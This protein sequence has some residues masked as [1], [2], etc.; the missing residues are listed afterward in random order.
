MEYINNELCLG[1]LKKPLLPLCANYMR[2]IYVYDLDFLSA[3]FKTMSQHLKGVRL[4]YA[5][6]ANSNPEI[7]Q[8]LKKL[9]AGADVVSLGEIK[10]ALE[11]GFSVQ[12]IVYS[13][14][15]KTRH[16]ITEALKLGIYQIN[17]ESLPELERI[18]AL[19]RS[20]NK[21]T[22]IALRLNPDIDIKTHPYIATGLKDN[23]FGMELGLIPELIK[24]LK[25]YAD[26]IEL[27][28]VSLHLG[29]MMMEFSGYQEALLKLKSVFVELQKEFSTLKRFD[30]GGGL[31]IFYDR[32]DLELEESL[33]K[34]YAKITLE[35]LG[36]LNCELQSEPGRWLVGHC[37]ALITQVQYI[38][39]TKDKT[40]VIVDAGMN[41]LIRPSLYEADH[42]ILP[43]KKASAEMKADIVGP[44]C[45]S[46]DFFAK[47]RTLG[48]VS[49]GDF[50]AVLDSGAYGY[51]MASIY[52]LQELP[53][54]ICI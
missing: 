24:T 16:E 3:R 52:N 27:V 31:G 20:L 50:V 49:E 41:H 15:G 2:P 28:G 48:S 54:E 34:D 12:D 5:M 22:S 17:V 19:A 26:C 30:F 11:S 25:S 4:F 10:R 45:E 1:P 18:G 38:K 23:K 37:G 46:S 21:K 6:K 44:I 9:G 35:T 43:L 7:L 40:F 8:Q 39:K 36:D 29:S 33:L 42:L 13:G 32:L 14:V 47:D 51:S 53:L